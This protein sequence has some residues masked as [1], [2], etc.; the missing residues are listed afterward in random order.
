MNYRL[1]PLAMT[2]V[3]AAGVATLTGCNRDVAVSD[4][5]ASTTNSTT[6][7]SSSSMASSTTSLGTDVDDTMIT[8]KVKAAL[9]GNDDVKGLD[10]T[11]ETRKGTVML[12]GSVDSIAQIDR[13]VTVT[14]GVE[15]V[16]NTENNMTV[17]DD[18]STTG[19]LAD[20]GR[21]T[22]RK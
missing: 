21:L 9:L 22:A 16:K 13:A 12:S 7:P 19:N 6:S 20:D 2:L 10:I 11:V 1:I 14:R 3:L 5:A 17:R 15:G 4:P 8:T 18:K